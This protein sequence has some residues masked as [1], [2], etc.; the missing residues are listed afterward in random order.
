MWSA[1]INYLYLFRRFFMSNNTFNPRSLGALQPFVENNPVTIVA[2][3][4]PLASDK[5]QIGQVWINSNTNSVYILTSI[6]V[7]RFIWTDLNGGSETFTTLVV[8]GLGSPGQDA[9]TVDTGDISILEGNLNVDG[10]TVLTGNLQ[11]VGNT[12][13]ADMAGTIS[14]ST[15]EANSSAIAFDASGV[16]GGIEMIADVGGGILLFAHGNVRVPPATSTA[17]SPAVAVEIDQWVGVAT[18]TGF[19]TAMGASETFDISNSRVTTTSGLI[20]SAVNLNASG[21][22]GQIAVTGTLQGAGA[23]VVTITNNGVG[24][25]GAGD[26]ILISFWVLA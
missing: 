1:L 15:T 25:L 24:D 11:V 21:N 10:N 26:D 17:A 13:I 9:I 5:A 7:G 3:R 22:G 14:F 23:F 16:D 18:F 12:I 2:K 19:T 4:N 6:V 20:V 8:T